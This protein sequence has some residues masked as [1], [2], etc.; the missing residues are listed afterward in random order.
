MNAQVLSG[1]C[2]GDN[3]AWCSGQGLPEQHAGSVCVCM[4]GVCVK[5][6]VQ[7]AYP[8]RTRFHRRYSNASF[9]A[10][11]IGIPSLP[12]KVTRSPCMT[13]L[14]PSCMSEGVCVSNEDMVVH[15]TVGAAR[16]VHCYQSFG[17]ERGRASLPTT[18]FDKRATVAMPPTWP[19]P[20]V[21]FGRGPMRWSVNTPST[22][23]LQLRKP[24]STAFH[25]EKVSCI[26]Y[27]TC[28]GTLPPPLICVNQ[29]MIFTI[30]CCLLNE[31]DKGVC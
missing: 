22:L 27:S 1:A 10:S 3:I 2:G 19:G 31:G 6:G 30:T 24:F 8:L 18:R 26:A 23:L 5:A 11:W 28:M 4:G 9:R 17:V 14:P 21:I 29:I 16:P 13:T 12:S 25:W 7:S 15:A 20:L